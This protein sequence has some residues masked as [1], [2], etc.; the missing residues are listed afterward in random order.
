MKPIVVY[1][2]KILNALSWFMPIG[3]ISLFPFIILREKF[4][5]QSK[6]WIKRNAKTVNH[7]SIHFYQA[8][9]LGVIGFY[10]LYLIEWFVK[11]FFYGKQA[12]RNISFEREAYANDSNIEYLNTRK[13]YSWLK[14]MF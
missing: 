5:T 11:L 8:L 12:Y 3:G 13:R 9:E 10:A 6:F 7:E 4:Q 14:L 1:N 2:D